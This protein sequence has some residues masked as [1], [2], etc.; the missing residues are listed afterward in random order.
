MAFINKRAL[1]STSRALHIYISTAL[2]FLLILFCVSGIV[3]NHVDWL[4]ND[5]NN[6]QISTPIP[7]AL[8]AKANAQ[9]STLPTLYPEIE[10]YLA[11]QY[12]LTN[13]KSIEWEKEDALVMLDYPLPAGFAYAEL[14]FISGTLNLDYQTGGFLSLIGDLHK[15]RHSGEAWSWVI[16]IS[17]VLMILFAITGM[18]ILFQ[19]RKKRLAGIWITVLGIAT[20]VVIYL[21]WVPQLK[22][23]Y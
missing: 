5:K 12:A 21:C 13:V 19:N 22:G 1:Y 10:A 15:G 8:A 16:D 17:A 2:F 4:K 6:G 7:S 11:K 20:P 3:L 18:I 9:L 23:V 14:D